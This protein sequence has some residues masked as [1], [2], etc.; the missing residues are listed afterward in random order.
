M[1]H[2]LA[3]RPGIFEFTLRGLEAPLIFRHGFGKSCEVSLNI[4][5]DEVN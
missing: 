4:F 5:P 3:K 2:L 1:L